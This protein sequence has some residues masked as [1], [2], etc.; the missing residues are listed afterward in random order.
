M[1]PCDPADQVT[2]ATTSTVRQPRADN[3]GSRTERRGFRTISD[4]PSRHKLKDKNFL[5]VHRFS[6]GSDIRT[7]CFKHHP[8]SQVCLSDRTFGADHAGRSHGYFKFRD[9]ANSE[10]ATKAEDDETDAEAD[11][12]SCL[13]G[14]AG[15]AKFPQPIR[16]ETLM[17]GPLRD[18]Y[19]CFSLPSFTEFPISI[20]PYT[21]PIR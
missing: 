21:L 7:P 9:L 16:T 13:R 5:C 14:E 4:C 15:V 6:I 20:H 18:V 10:C 8:H 11:G 12:K 2:I 17:K 19:D 1:W 3:A